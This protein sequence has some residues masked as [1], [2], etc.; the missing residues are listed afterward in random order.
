MRYRS[1]VLL[2]VLFGFTATVSAQETKRRE[3]KR[4]VIV[5][6]ELVLLVIASQPGVPIQ[7]QDAILLMSEDGRDLIVSYNLYNSGVKPIRYLTPMM[8]TSFDTG[9]TLTG[10]GPMSGVT[11]GELIMPG[12]I[13]KDSQSEIVPLTKESREKLKLLSPAKTMVI[14]MVKSITFADGSIF[15]DDATLKATQGYFEDL[16]EKMSLLESLQRPARF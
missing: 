15:N 12:Q 4:Y 11:S 7:F 6:S 9:G 1:I 2:L 3:G 14:L 10:S 16:S 8:W 5:P 13:V